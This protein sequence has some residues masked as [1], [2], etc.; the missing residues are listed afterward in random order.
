MLTLFGG[1]ISDLTPMLT[2]ERFAPNWEPRVLSR[3]GLT[4]AKF[5][6][7]V[8]PVQMGVNTKKIE[9]MEAAGSVPAEGNAPPAPAMATA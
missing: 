9:Q 8:F 4:M 1:S 5:N 6:G 2:D 7:T 3:F